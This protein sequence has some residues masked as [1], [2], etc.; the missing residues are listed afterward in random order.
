MYKSISYCSSS[1]QCSLI[2]C[3]IHLYIVYTD[4]KE[5]AVRRERDRRQQW[6]GREDRKE[7][8]ETE[9]RQ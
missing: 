4:R 2:L 5:S 3:L 8:G 7:S 9:L 6:D 1:L